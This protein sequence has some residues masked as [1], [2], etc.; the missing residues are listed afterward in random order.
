MIPFKQFKQGSGVEGFWQESSGKFQALFSSW[1]LRLRDPSYPAGSRGSCWPIALDGGGAKAQSFV[2][3]L[4]TYFELIFLGLGTP[5]PPSLQ[6]PAVMLAARPSAREGGGRRKKKMQHPKLLRW[7][8]SKFDTKIHSELHCFPNHNPKWKKL[9]STRPWLALS[10]GA[11]QHEALPSTRD[12]TC[13][14]WSPLPMICIARR[15]SRQNV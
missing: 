6:S 13:L 15:G 12:L 14:D 3:V 5:P 1:I 2:F 4:P 10:T 8:A 11:W 9:R 7:N